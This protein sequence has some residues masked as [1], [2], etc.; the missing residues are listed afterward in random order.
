MDFCKKY[1]KDTLIDKSIKAECVT[2]IKYLH[3]IILTGCFNNCIDY[4][5]IIIYLATT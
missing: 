2:L 5:N 4:D 1:S 3:S